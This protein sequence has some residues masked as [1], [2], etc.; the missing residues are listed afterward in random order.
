[1][2][3]NLWTASIDDCFDA[4]RLSWFR[5]YSLGSN[6]LWWN[7]S[8][9]CPDSHVVHIPDN[10]W[11]RSIYMCSIVVFQIMWLIERQLSRDY[12]RQVCAPRIDR[13]ASHP[14]F[15]KLT[16]FWISAGIFCDCHEKQNSTNVLFVSDS[17][18]V[19]CH[20]RNGLLESTD[21]KGCAIIS[22]TQPPECS[23]G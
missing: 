8:L 19:S 11:K 10:H 14:V 17:M 1:M 3:W 7:I 5:F 2:E 18:I 20:C 22:S 6:N 23:K 12:I 16:E 13:P 21:V 9:R 15:L 4:K